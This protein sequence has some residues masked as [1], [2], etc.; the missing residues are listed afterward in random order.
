MRRASKLLLV[1]CG[2]LFLAGCP[3]VPPCGQFTFTGTEDDGAVSNSIDASVSFDF[4]PAECGSDC[5]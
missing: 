4:D 5:S 3:P 1:L 2:A